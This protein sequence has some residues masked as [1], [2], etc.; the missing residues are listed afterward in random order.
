[1]AFQQE[2]LNSRWRYNPFTGQYL[3]K[4]ISQERQSVSLQPNGL[5]GFYLNEAVYDATGYPV[6]MTY[7]IGGASLTETT[8]TPSAGQ[9]RVDYDNKTGFIQTHSSDNGKYILT[10]YHGIGTVVHTVFDISDVSPVP[11]HTF[12]G[13]VHVEYLFSC[14]GSD[15]IYKGTELSETLGGA[16][17]NES[18]WDTAGATTQ[19]IVTGSKAALVELIGGGG[20]GGG[21]DDGGTYVYG[22]DGGGSG[23]RRF[24]II[25][26]NGTSIAKFT[27]TVGAGGSGGSA[28]SSGADGGATSIVF[29]TAGDVVVSTYSVD[30]G[31]GG[32]SSPGFGSARGLDNGQFGE[33]SRF[34]VT[35]GGAA[36]GHG[37]GGSG[38]GGA[39][40]N[41]GDGA[42]PGDGGGGGD[43]QPGGTAYAGGAGADGLVRIY[44]A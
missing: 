25:N 14:I 12:S 18:S 20:G 33:Y 26:F 21:G 41:G 16:F 10:N 32:T 40:S 43:G 39:N 35:A 22:G 30:G 42:N 6:S 27:A 29:K 38:E 34:E 13:P 7:V 3:P 5:Y 44:W 28:N 11:V 37:G 36:G 23:M 19:N 31:K 15:L 9:F 24:F 2:T 17:R 8:D 1:M 4:E